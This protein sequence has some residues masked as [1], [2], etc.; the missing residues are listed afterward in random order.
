MI[1]ERAIDMIKQAQSII[2]KR[3]I[4]VEC[5]NNPKVMKFYIDNG[6]KHIGH[7]DDN[8]LEQMIYK[9]NKVY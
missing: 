9:L 8:N 5:S 6:F 3:A 4:L 2:G 1:L 7:N